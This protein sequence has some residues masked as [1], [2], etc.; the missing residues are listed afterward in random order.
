[1][2]PRCRRPARRLRVTGSVIVASAAIAIAMLPLATPASAQGTWTVTLGAPS[3]ATT[4][5]FVANGTV[6]PDGEAG[7]VQIVY[8]PSGTPITSSSPTA[9]LVIFNAGVT[10]PQ[11]VSIPVDQLTPNTSYTY[12]LQATE[13]DNDAVF[14]SAPGTFS[15]TASPTGPGTPIKPPNNPSANGIFGQCSGDPACVNDMNGV[16][17]AQEQL[18]PLALPTNWS[19]LTGPEQMFVW[20]DLERTS[21]AEVAIPNL[22]NTYNAAVQAGLTNDAD[23][24]LSDL[25]G[26]SGSIWA[27]AYATVLGA[28]YGWLYDDGPGGENADCTGTNTSGCWGHRDNILADANTYGNPTE[29]D[30][31]VGTDSSGNADYDAIFVV[32]P[33]ATAPANIVFTWAEEQPFLAGSTFAPSI[34]GVTLSGTPAAPTVTVTGSNF[35]SA[36]P[37]ATPE[38]C[39][40]GDTGNDYGFGGLEFQDLTEG[41]GAGESGD[42][43]GLLLTSWSSTKVVFT[44]GNEYANYGPINAGDQIEVT[45][46]GATDTVPASFTAVPTVTKVSPNTGPTSGGTAI[47]I[48]GTGFVAGATVVI[49]QGN[50][51]TGAIAATSVKVVSSTEITATTGGGAKAGTFSLFV[52]TSGGTSAANAGADFS[53]TV[54]PKVSKV[55]PNAGPTKGG[56]AITITGTGFVAGAKVVIGQ[57]NGTTGAIAATSV[58]VVSSTEITAVTGGGAKAGTFSLFV[59]TTGGTSAANAGAD[60]SYGVTVTKVSPNTGPTSGGTAITITGTG[61]VAGATVVIGQGNGTTGAIAATSVK[62]VSP[63]EITAVTGGGAKAGTFSLFVTTSAGTSAASTGADFTYS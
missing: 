34:S 63:T 5:G 31:G 22:V 17:A 56:T 6:T 51:T 35:G 62:V 59:T 37:T 45:V 53:Y 19:T 10:T 41:W 25:P 57:G 39:Q 16:R 2:L 12:E 61:F 58:K 44:F 60:F 52:T 42:C 38:T 46:Q 48:T 30:A 7:F 28:I 9:G 50:G 55:S 54:L 24:S 33:N 21:R 14:D 15:T 11:A 27:G 40:A 18:P 49:G 29:M 32:N 1:M 8:E 26:N 13:D 43:I 47:T 3:G 4:T 23:P 36:A 20:A